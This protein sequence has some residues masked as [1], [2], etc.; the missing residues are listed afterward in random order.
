MH[1]N[2]I[3][4]RKIVEMGRQ[5]SLPVDMRRPTNAHHT[6]ATLVR[7]LKKY[8]KELIIRRQH[9]R[10]LELACD[11]SSPSMLRISSQSRVYQL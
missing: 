4:Y 11:E 1:M 9:L 10:R 5:S 2:D 3:N 8:Q 7:K 6:V